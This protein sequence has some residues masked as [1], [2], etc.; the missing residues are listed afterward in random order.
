MRITESR[1]RRLIRSVIKENLSDMHTNVVSKMS[2]IR[3]R[4]DFLEA[5]D[6][7]IKNDTKIIQNIRWQNDGV[8]PEK[9]LVDITCPPTA[10]GV[11][12]Y[13]GDPCDFSVSRHAGEKTGSLSYKFTSED[14]SVSL[15]FGV[16]C[17]ITP[18][19]LSNDY[20]DE[21]PGECV[22]KLKEGP[23]YNKWGL[24]D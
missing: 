19:Y 13:Y 9:Y 20:D 21:E 1:L 18:G 15:S 22:C 6:N 14:E 7:F 11:D 5:V 12:E 2:T 17:Y 23:S 10:D 24:G 3:T 16:E 8:K 4:E